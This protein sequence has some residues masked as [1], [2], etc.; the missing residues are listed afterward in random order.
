[1]AHGFLCK[2]CDHQESEHDFPADYP[3]VCQAYQSPDRRLERRIW[4]SED[5][6]KPRGPISSAV[7]ILT[8]TGFI[9]IGS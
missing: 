9:D 5:D 6:A 2:R 8:P 1:M 4:K 7:W 3:G